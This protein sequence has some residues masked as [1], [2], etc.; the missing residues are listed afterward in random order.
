[1]KKI[2]VIGQV[3]ID[4][5]ARPYKEIVLYDKNPGQ[6]KFSYGGVGRNICENLARLGLHPTFLTIVGDDEFGSNA[7]KNLEKL[8]VKTKYIKSINP[9]NT[10]I[11]FLDNNHDNYL[12]VSSMDIIEEFDDKLLDLVNIKDYDLIVCD[13]NNKAIINSL[14]DL[15]KPLF[16]DATSVARASNLYGCLDFISYLKCTNEELYEIFKSDNISCIVNKY[17]NLTLVVTD[18]TNDIRYNIAN[19]V[20]C[21]SVECVETVNAVGAGDSFSAGLIYGLFYDKSMSVCV[22]YAKKIAKHTVMQQDTVS[23]KICKEMLGD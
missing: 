18:K 6:A 1:M 9:T 13:A 15:K 14:K 10:F 19:K 21:T 16:V 20:Y 11:S 17:P 5:V 7:I 3:N 22:D 12:A 23:K 2:L 4:I 8:N